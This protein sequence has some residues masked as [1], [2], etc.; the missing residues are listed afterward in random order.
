MKI[1]F[2]VDASGQIGTG[3]FMRCLTLADALHERGAQIHFV[4]RYLPEYLHVMLAAKGYEFTLLKST[5]KEIISEDLFHAHW[6]GTSQHADAQDTTQALSGQFWDWLVVDH[7]ALDVRWESELRQTAKNILVIDDLADRV[8]DCDV[9][10]DQNYYADMVN[11]YTNKVPAHCRLLLGPRYAL[12]R[13]EFRRMRE[14][15]KPRSG[16]VK[17]ILVFFGGVDA[18]NYTGRAI[19]ALVDIGSPGLC[20]DVVIG[21]Q[22]P[23]REQLEHT[24]ARHGFNC[25][26]Q[27][28]RMA[29][30]M[31]AADLAVGAGGATSWERC[32]LGLPTLTL[33]V[34]DNQQMLIEDSSRVGLLYTP[35]L[36]YDVISGLQ[37]H[38]QALIEN[39]ALRAL[40]S[41]NGLETVDGRG[42]LR[43]V[44]KIG[45]N[46]VKIR[47]AREEDSKDI[48]TWRNHPSIRAVS[49]NKD[50]I[51]LESHKQWLHGVLC[52]E[53][54]VLLI[55]YRD[56]QHPIGV[57]RFDMGGDCAKVSIY[58][59]PGLNGQGLGCE[60]LESAEQWLRSNFPDIQSVK[61]DVMGDNTPSHRLFKTAGYIKKSTRYCKK[62]R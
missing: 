36:E 29:E 40:I 14:Q 39:P 47:L 3:H 6:L 23:F 11:R 16:P 48:M 17:R 53:N 51:S 54:R 46:S 19:E 25:H 58:L 4:S 15:V 2:R 59:V 38:I 24:C 44:H 61:A 55:G 21:A 7:Y 8:H 27:T 41:R 28:T 42:A 50:P 45:C 18:D 10:L 26:V 49:S 30:L 9:L 35:V 37:R 31:A 1:A 20:V 43:V 32:C 56:E 12:L 60:L 22:H 5:P 34:A 13:E 57:V 33:C 62:V 52:D